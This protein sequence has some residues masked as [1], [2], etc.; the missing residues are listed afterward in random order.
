MNNV[1]ELR[2]RA[3]MTQQ[4]LATL[5][6]VSRQYVSAIE[7]GAEKLSPVT[8]AKLQSIFNCTEEEIVKQA[9][10]EY[11]EEGRFIV[12]KIWD[13]PRFPNAVVVQIENSYFVLPSYCGYNNNIPTDKQLTPMP[14]KLS[15][16]A[17]ELNQRYYVLF[18]NCTKRNGFDVQIGRAITDDELEELK[19]K[20]NL[21]EDDISEEFIDV[22]GKLFGK[23]GKQY[24]A[25]QIKIPAGT[26]PITIETELTEKGIQAFNGC[27]GRINIRVK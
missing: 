6:S 13:D 8:I 14:T 7:S 9:E 12:D 21:S 23:W 20:L 1:K 17:T 4:K 5:L 22:K 2:T 16:N 19:R 3:S 10:F 26:N 11:N 25:I 18:Y 15:S 24:T 27:E